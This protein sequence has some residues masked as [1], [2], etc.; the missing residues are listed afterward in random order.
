MPFSSYG[1]NSLN[2]LNIQINAEKDKNFNYNNDK[3]GSK[4]DDGNNLKI[5]NTCVEPLMS[6][7]DKNDDNTNHTNNNNYNNR[8]NPFSPIENLDYMKV[9]QRI[10]REKMNSSKSLYSDMITKILNTEKK[11]DKIDIGD[12]SEKISNVFKKKIPMKKENVHN[13]FLE[14][15][16]ETSIIIILL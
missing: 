12:K 2:T 16:E 11:D 5:I 13:I 10:K 15:I 9:S 4:V 1:E 6:V 8:P 7:N 3:E 14:E